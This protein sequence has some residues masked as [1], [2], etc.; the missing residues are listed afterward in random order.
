MTPGDAAA[1]PASASLR[2]SEL[3]NWSR[4]SAPA[5]RDGQ[6][7]DFDLQAAVASRIRH[8][9]FLQNDG[10]SPAAPNSPSVS[11]PVTPI[12]SIFYIGS[13]IG[14]RRRDQLRPLCRPNRHRRRRRPLLSPARTAIDAVAENR[15]G[16]RPGKAA[17][18]SRHRPGAALVL[19]P[20]TGSISASRSKYGSRCG[21]A[22]AQA[23][24]SAVSVV[25][26]SAAVIDGRLSALGAGAPSCR[27]A[28]G[29]PDARPAGRHGSGPGR[30]HVAVT[31]ARSR[32]SLR[33]SPR[34]LLDTNV[35]FKEL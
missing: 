6:W 20:T 17:P 16:L 21:G 14:R 19:R 34:Y 3:W 13:F 1:S 11:A 4:R 12:S 33:S 23:V 27:D 32:A 31:P 24:V 2:R 28:Q 22:L 10:T 25:D 5:R 26:F 18:R 7:R 9:W 15:L 35:L 30:R 29:P 8:P